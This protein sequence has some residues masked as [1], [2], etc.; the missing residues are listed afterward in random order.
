MEYLS[1]REAQAFPEIELFVVYDGQ[2][3]PDMS[4]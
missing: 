3:S 4:I 1:L 2:M